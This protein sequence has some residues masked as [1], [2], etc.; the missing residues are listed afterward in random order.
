MAVINTV[1][2]TATLVKGK[3][4]FRY[5]LTSPTPQHEGSVDISII[6]PIALSSRVV[7]GVGG[8]VVPPPPALPGTPV[9]LPKPLPGVTRP[10]DGFEMFMS[11]MGSAGDSS[12]RSTVFGVF[13][14]NLL[15][16]ASASIHQVINYKGANRI[17]IYHQDS[18]SGP[19][20]IK[21]GKFQHTFNTHLNAEALAIAASQSNIIRIT[22]WCYVDAQSDWQKVARSFDVTSN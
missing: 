17:T 3:A 4:T 8:K 10:T 1:T 14:N 20:V 18:T 11:N 7:I 5:P 19:I 21:N 6:P 9:T 13:P 22:Y 12:V 15:D 16:G 2:G